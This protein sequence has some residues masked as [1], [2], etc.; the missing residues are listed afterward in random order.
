MNHRS[1]C[2]AEFKCMVYATQKSYW[3]QLNP[4]AHAL[5][6][7]HPLKGWHLRESHI[8]QGER[9]LWRETDLRWTTAL[10]S[11]SYVAL[12]ETALF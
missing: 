8:M 9:Q 4:E 5:H 7:P 12:D 3:L 6:Q 1:T 10:Q 2:E 11:P